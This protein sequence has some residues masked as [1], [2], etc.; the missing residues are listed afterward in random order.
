MEN[1]T[2]KILKLF[3]LRKKKR[4]KEAGGEKKMKKLTG[5]LL[6]LFLAILSFPILAQVTSGMETS[7]IPES[8]WIQ[9]TNHSAGADFPAWSP[10]GSEIVYVTWDE[11]SLGT[12]YKMDADGTNH[13]SYGPYGVEKI[14]YPAVSPDGTKISMTGFGYVWLVNYDGTNFH[15]IYG[16]YSGGTCVPGAIQSARWSP[17]GDKLAVDEMTSCNPHK[18]QIVVID[19]NGS[20]PTVITGSEQGYFYPGWSPDGTKIAYSSFVHLVDNARGWNA[21]IWVMD[22]DGENHRRLTQFD[23]AFLPVWSPDGSSIFFTRQP[24]SSGAERHIFRVDADGTNIVQLTDSGGEWW[25]AISPDGEWIAFTAYDEHGFQNVYKAKLSAPIL[26]LIPDT[27]FSSTTVVG[28][29]FATDSKVTFMWDNTVTPAVPSPLITDSNGSFTAIISV[30]TQN[31]PGPHTVKATDESGNWATATFTVIDMT[32][33]QGLQ[34]QEGD[35]GP[36]GPEGPSGETRELSL[37]VDAFT[38]A[39]SVIA[40]CLATIALLRKRS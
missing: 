38:I 4:A 12:L 6:V 3:N 35:T 22:S 17:V 13:V 5:A 9:L 7:T 24:G 19:S 2:E 31:N 37:I 11:T 30:L 8:R 34:G 28:S 23:D 1:S 16:I 29:G 10:D 33:P 39:A 21:D 36:Q 40:I 26:D 25:P 20:N 27:G 15:H 14:G 18:S 32:G